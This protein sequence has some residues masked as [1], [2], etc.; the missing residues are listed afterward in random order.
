MKRL[1][2]VR[3]ILLFSLVITAGV[4]LLHPGHAKADTYYADSAPTN[5]V[6]DWIDNQI[7]EYPN[8]PSNPYNVCSYYKSI[9]GPQTIWALWSSPFE[10][11]PP[12]S[13][14]SYAIQ[15][16]GT[17]YICPG[18]S[19]SS[20]TNGS[21]SNI[22]GTYPDGSPVSLSS[23]SFP[24]G[25]PP[26]RGSYGS[27]GAVTANLDLTKLPVDGCTNLTVHFTVTAYYGG[28]PSSAS[29]SAQLYICYNP[30]PAPIPNGSC[31]LLSVP[32]SVIAGSSFSAY[33]N[34]TNTGNTVWSVDPSIPDRF[35]LGLP[36]GAHNWG[37]S[38]INI[39]GQS[40]DFGKVVYPGD[41]YNT[42]PYPVIFTAP[43]TPGTYDFTWQVLREFVAWYGTPCTK[44]I[45]VKAPTTVT[46]AGPATVEI[47]TNATFNALGGDG[48]SY[49]WLASGGNPAS[50][51]GSSTTFVTK[52]SSLGTK[53]VAVVSGGDSDACTIDVVKST[54]PYIRVYNGDV[55]VG[56]GFQTS[57]TQNSG[58]GI[59]AYDVG[60]TPGAGAGT[61]IAAFALNTVHRFSTANAHPSTAN[62]APHSGLTFAD[63]VV[64]AANYGGTFGYA[65]CIKDYYTQATT[66]PGA[67]NWTSN[68][69]PATQGA[70]TVVNDGT[71]R[72]YYHSGNLTITGN[73]VYASA[74][75]IGWGLASDIPAFYII[76]SGNIKI[77]SN[78]TQ[79]DGV[80]IAQ[81]VP[82]LGGAGGYIYTCTQSDGSFFDASN[83]G[84]SCSQGLTFNGAVLANAIR[85]L[86]TNGDYTTSSPNEAHSNQ[87]IAETF[88][89]TPEVWLNSPFAPT[90]P[91]QSITNLPPVL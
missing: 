33:M 41:T 91:Y 75:S 86:R 89:Y 36:A 80:Y 4:V 34:A 2:K 56:T 6:P 62:P 30:Q 69:F 39:D 7:W 8:Y 54:Y 31:S 47:N 12:A 49:I 61:E 9:G 68:T 78:V 40:T 71:K 25:S 77:A 70:T 13:A 73:V 11:T 84:N 52:Y 14:T 74:D 26:G 27:I 76:A 32:S 43:S 88:V 66:I 58:A 50:Q 82:Q 85:L 23:T 28:S 16:K 19:Y 81:G 57:C 10:I 51:S 64:S 1:L 45:T 37:I 3:Y 90:A 48:S 87:N 65:P 17:A 5:G 46:C 44:Q 72:I 60:S 63:K 15:F 21:I 20:F 38:R 79:L 18:A 35:L 29:G 59:V 55:M 22:S 83:I 67:V 42:T 53:T 24:V